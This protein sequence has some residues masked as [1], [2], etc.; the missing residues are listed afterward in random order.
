MAETGIAEHTVDYSICR[1]F[2]YF[3]SLVEIES[4]DHNNCHF[5]FGVLTL[6]L[7]LPGSPWGVCNKGK[8]DGLSL[9]YLLIVDIQ[10]ACQGAGDAFSEASGG[11]HFHPVSP[12]QYARID[13]LSELQFHS[14]NYRAVKLEPVSYTHLTLPTN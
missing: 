3:F 9:I 13:V 8:L 1:L 5:C 14:N 4:F 2:V 7:C 6:L 10:C 11:K 12:P